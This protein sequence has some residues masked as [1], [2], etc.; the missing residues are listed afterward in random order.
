MPL[1]LALALTRRGL[2]V[3]A[4]RKSQSTANLPAGRVASKSSYVA[5][6]SRYA[7]QLVKLCGQ[8]VKLCG[9]SRGLRGLLS[10][11]I[12]ENRVVFHWCHFYRI[13]IRT[14]C[15]RKQQNNSDSYKWRSWG[16]RL[17]WGFLI[18]RLV[19]PQASANLPCYD[20]QAVPLL[21]A[22]CRLCRSWRSADSA[23]SSLF[24]RLRLF[25][26]HFCLRIRM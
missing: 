1:L 4:V 22:L 24:E 15:I 23:E 9:P 5:K 16:L 20:P 2:C 7:S 21:P 8:L 13:G 3:N 12:R 17:P 26:L 25:A 14:S 10:E 19:F 11:A 6:W 18:E